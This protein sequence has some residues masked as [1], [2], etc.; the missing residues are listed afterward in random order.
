V[1]AP[2]KKLHVMHSL[3]MISVFIIILARAINTLG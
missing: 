2:I 1:G 3:S